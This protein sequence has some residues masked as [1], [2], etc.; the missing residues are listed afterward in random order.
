MSPFQKSF[1]TL[2]DLSSI[3]TEIHSFASSSQREKVHPNASDPSYCGLWSYS[4]ASTYDN[5][6]DMSILYKKQSM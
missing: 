2:T 3:E 4:L 5:W 6:S 1:E